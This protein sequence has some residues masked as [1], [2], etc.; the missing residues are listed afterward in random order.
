MTNVK[1]RQD[2]IIMLIANKAYNQPLLDSGLLFQQDVR[3]NFYY[4]SYL[5]AAAEDQALPFAGDREAAKSKAE[6][7]LFHLLE[8]Q[9]QSAESETYGHWPLS[10]WP[11]PQEAAKNTLPVEL[12]GSL[13]V[14]FYKRYAH[15]M[16]SELRSSFDTVLKHIYQSNFYRKP[17]SS[18]NHHEAKYTA[19]KLVFGQLYEDKALVEDGYQSLC[20]T[21][22]RIK[23]TGMVEYGA[24]PWF[25][26]WVQAFTC[27][28]ELTEDKAIQTS[29]AQM[30]DYLWDV[31]A[32]YYLGGAWVGSHSRIW[33][34]D[35][36]RDTNV[37]HDY[38]QFGDFRLSDVMPRTE[39]AGF[40]VYEASAVVRD[41]ALNRSAATEIK[42]QVPKQ[43]GQA[44]NE[45]DVLHTYAYLT[46]NFAVGGIW[47][48]IAEFDNE[49]HRW[50]ISLPLD[51]AAGVNHLYFFHPG[52][53]FKE[54]DLRHQSEYTEV[55][56]HRNTVI[57]SYLIPDDQPQQ[58]WGC[59]P[60]GEWVE[61]SNGLFG[62]CGNVLIAIFIQQAYQ[63]ELQSDR[64]VVTS[65]NNQ[66]AVV[67][68]VI[69]LLAAQAQG[70]ESLQQFASSMNSRQPAF[71][72]SN[73][74]FSLTYK[75]LSAEALVLTCGTDRKITRLVNGQPVDFAAYT[76]T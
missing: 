45:A 46:E 19:A 62:L 18:Y 50:D 70:I 61:M 68:E 55:L 57:A 24:L 64:S 5:F 6:N 9:D 17:V 36:P 21:L 41:K 76:V 8:L 26:H 7:V 38:V 58:I 39:Y 32:T 63:R 10:L 47:E 27:A 69:D 25:W 34:H 52:D 75:T 53:K 16:N 1:Q 35:M 12:M 2:E 48:R 44:S 72:T 42:R 54:G 28:W 33:P 49:Q 29:L 71:L 73:D 40:L 11:T 65:T 22:D 66:N 51:A 20:L 3:D 4:A 60:I 74:E 31:R 59:L 56:F 13:M 30:L 37:L 14:Y 43:V 15:A 23:T 67:V